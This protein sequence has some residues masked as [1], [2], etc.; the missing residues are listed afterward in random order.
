MCRSIVEDMALVGKSLDINAALRAACGAA[1]MIALS[2]GV[3]CPYTIDVSQFKEQC[4]TPIK[5]LRYTKTSSFEQFNRACVFLRAVQQGV[6]P[7]TN[8]AR[9]PNQEHDELLAEFFTAVKTKGSKEPL[10][11]FLCERFF[12]IDPSNYDR[13]SV[14]FQDFM[15]ADG[16]GRLLGA[17][18]CEKTNNILETQLRR[19]FSVMKDGPD[20]LQQFLE[21]AEYTDPDNLAI[22]A[23]KKGYDSGLPIEVSVAKELDKLNIFILTEKKRADIREHLDGKYGAKTLASENS[24]VPL[25]N[26]YNIVIQD[27]QAINLPGNAVVDISK[28]SVVRYVF[29]KDVVVDVH[30]YLM[31]LLQMDPWA[32]TTFMVRSFGG[33][34]IPP[35]KYP[36]AYYIIAHY[37]ANRPPY[38]NPVDFY[39][40]PIKPT[41][42]KLPIM[43]AA[44]KANSAE[45]KLLIAEGYDWLKDK[46]PSISELIP[47]L[48]GGAGNVARHKVGKAV[49]AATGFFRDIGRRFTRSQGQSGG[50]RVTRKV[51]IL[52]VNG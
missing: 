30:P 41:N 1:K 18:D 46:A 48:G 45:L 42:E 6:P 29:D 49:S 24:N 21:N 28:Q 9:L 34:M 35:V 2:Q 25:D 5:E 51:R 4:G 20:Y 50:R 13:I 47:W 11:V 26:I 14:A 36:L 32:S 31:Y 27:G 40:L 8:I 16:Q 3:E 17:Y 44:L 39:N 52:P 37:V 10:D 7:P 33:N 23:K 15:N 12:R 38:T 43:L 19:L 22:L